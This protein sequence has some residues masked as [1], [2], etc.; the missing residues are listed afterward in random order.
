MPTAGTAVTGPC[1]L[2]SLRLNVTDTINQLFRYT[3][4]RD[5]KLAI[6]MFVR[7][8]GLTAI[9]GKARA[10]LRDHPQ[11]VSWKTASDETE[12]RATVHWP[13]DERR[14]ADLNAFL[15]LVT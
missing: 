6:V 7:Q 10:T 9:L 11:F 5:T 4:W 12:L 13:G 14:L 1:L 3:G 8:K 2:S 15:T